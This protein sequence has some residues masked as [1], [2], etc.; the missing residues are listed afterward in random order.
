MNME[1]GDGVC[2]CVSR[3]SPQTVITETNSIYAHLPHHLHLTGQPCTRSNT[4]LM[5]SRVAHVHVRVVYGS[6]L[7]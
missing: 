1:A 4:S 6:V 7:V 3:L 5:D 2:V